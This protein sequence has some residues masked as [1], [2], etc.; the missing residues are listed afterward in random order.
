FMDESPLCLVSSV[1][2]GRGQ[3]LPFLGRAFLTSITSFCRFRG[4]F[5]TFGG[6]LGGFFSFGRCRGGIDPILFTL[7]AAFERG[8]LFGFLS[9]GFGLL[10]DQ[11]SLL[12]GQF[13]HLHQGVGLD[14]RQVVVRQKALA[15]QPL[16]EAFI[17][18]FQR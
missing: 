7:P 1:G 3:R 16:A 14:D 4:R 2:R 8:S 9:L 17:H 13:S 15:H 12:L 5:A 6:R 10:H 11:R 18:A